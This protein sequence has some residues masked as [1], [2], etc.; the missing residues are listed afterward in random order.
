MSVCLSVHRAKDPEPKEIR[1]WLRMRW[2]WNLI[3]DAHF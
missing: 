2:T 3:A 1:D